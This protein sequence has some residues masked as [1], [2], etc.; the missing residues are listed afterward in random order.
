MSELPFARH[1]AVII[2]IDAYEKVSVLRTAVSDARR[3][4]EVLAGPQ[5]FTVHPPLLDAR[6][7]DLRTLLRE[8]LP[9][10]VA[11]DDRVLVYFAGHGI[12]ADGD[13]GP[14]GYLVPADA[15][16]H[17]VATLLPMTELQ[18]A[19]Q[20]L[21]CRHLLLVLDCCFSGAFQWASRSRAIGTVMPK[22]IYKERFDR[23]VLDPAWQVITSA[24]YDQKATDVLHGRATGDRGV[25][26]TPA[27][28]LHSPFAHALFDAL[29]G[30]ADMRTGRDGD[31]VITATEVYSYVRDRVEPET[32]AAGQRLR[33]TPG[34]FPLRRHDKGEF[35]FLHPRHRLNL[36]PRPSRSPYKGLQSF[37]EADASLFYGRDRAVAELQARCD[38]ARLVVVSGASG[39]GKSSLVKA[40]LLPLLR[41][42]GHRIL[43]VMR[44]GIHPV[45]ALDVALADA[46]VEGAPKGVLVID[47]FEELFTRCG[48]DDERQ[49]FLA[50]LRHVVDDT[51]RIHRVI[52]TVRSDFEPQV[53]AGALQ[54]AWNAGR[55]T[56]P[57]FSLDELKAVVVMPTLQEV[58]IFDPPDL[59]D[60]ITGDVVQSP[61]ALPL[62]AYALSE[63]YEAY[64]AS[65]RQDRAL[66]AADYERLGGV[67]GAL[68]SKAD[69]LYQALAPAEQATMRR[70]V[71]R[72]VS[73][74]GDLAGRRV[75]IADLDYSAEENPRVQT[76]I[77]RLVEA[78]LIVKGQDYVEPAH[79]ALVRA[80]KTLHD[81][82]HAVGRDVLLLGQ[83]LGPDADQFAK[84]RDPQL[85]WNRN[86]NLAVAARGL[87][88]PLHTLNAKEVAFV[89]KSVRRNRR[90]KVVAWLITAATVL[91]LLVLAV[92][93]LV[94]RGAA[95][96]EH[97]RALLSLFEGL[98]LNLSDGQP[99]SVCVLG[100]CDAAPTGDG[101]E[102]RSLGRLPEAMA[103]VAG[104]PRS[105][106]FAASRKY[107]GG[108]V[109][110]YAQ[111]GLTRDDEITPGSD[112]LL[113]A[114]N[115]LAW[116][117]PLELKTAAGCAPR[118]TI[119]VWEGTFTKLA[120][121]S[122]VQAFVERRG[123]EL[124]T[125]TPDT[126]EADL[127]CAE[128]LWYL[129]DWAP[130]PEF[131]DVLVP[132]IETFVVSGG[133]LLV[134]GL[135]WSYAEQ[136]GPNGVA[137]TAPYAADV[138]GQR[139]G[140]AFTRDAF[141]STGDTPITLEPGQ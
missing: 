91:S 71:L 62:L 59:V 137:A 72:L 135:G 118:I 112:N 22:R 82:I 120:Q 24:A 126:V 32:L 56:V 65:G 41:E 18:D 5:G 110:V 124:K 103:S 45:A 10:L 108:S 100:A 42:A 21:P 73:V 35:V 4:A 19:L 30:D 104:E 20:A 3:L 34:F 13:D 81:W 37:D 85:L 2:G 54:A 52:V 43:P 17:D 136:G 26:A 50:R 131:G 140:F 128:V 7:A 23:F 141:A 88:D 6:G 114:Q 105:R 111:D 63:L 86:P 39:T 75:P 95:Q 44:P 79:D 96:E 93:A 1:H 84:T 28:E 33:Q 133:G 109:V 97:E 55:W 38:S 51:A 70:I 94:E 123:W 40:G 8:T 132:E 9:R 115:A 101:G 31:G 36:P 139:F 127:A 64:R 53:S 57:P 80:W 99:G 87:T 67:M 15:D 129:S 90:R 69:A 89:R 98:S 125:T 119:L 14:A 25:S 92:W 47:Q 48:D 78:R 83:R 27:G 12:A 107:G 49:A 74:E 102:W 58:L 138:L 66:T 122:R 76:V 11:A 117:T 106:V 134:G 130:P 121:M 46:G 113:F 61:G 16:P 116:L 60:R 68:R 77:E 29:A